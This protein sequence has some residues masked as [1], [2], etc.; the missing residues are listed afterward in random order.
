MQAIRKLEILARGHLESVHVAR[1]AAVFAAVDALV[2][3]GEIAVSRLGRAIA[4][5]TGAKH[6]IKRVDRLYGNGKLWEQRSAFYRVIARTTIAAHGRSRPTLLVDWTESGATSCVLA[7]AIPAGGRAVVVY[8]ETHALTRYMNPEVEAEFL[9]RLRDVLPAGVRPII[10]TDAGFRAPWL[11]AVVA[12]GW[13]YVGR[14]RGRTRVRACAGG[15]WVKYTA[16]YQRARIGRPID[17][18]RHAVTRYKPYEARLVV[19]RGR[20]KWR[21]LPKAIAQRARTRAVECAKEPWLLATSLPRVS[22]KKIARLYAERMQIEQ[23]F[24]DTKS[25]RFGWGMN[26]TVS[27]DPRRIDIMMLITALASLVVLAAGRAAEA[28]GMQR[29]FQANTVRTRRVL[30][31]TTLG[32]LVLLHPLLNLRLERRHFELGRVVPS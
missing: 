14:I 26:G 13:D 32:R 22:A 6:G 24:R 7:A 1:V 23:T 31:L 19:C 18:G 2:R 10:V 28:V 17:L 30:A 16:L 9:R 8:A 21:P 29:L 5:K 20:T 27:R 15:S 12:L 25:E 4:M 3:G 11:R